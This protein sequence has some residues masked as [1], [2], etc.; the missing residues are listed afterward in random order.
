MKGRMSTT[1][2]TDALELPGKVGPAIL[3]RTYITGMANN[4]LACGFPTSFNWKQWQTAVV[5]VLLDPRFDPDKPVIKEMVDRNPREYAELL[6]EALA[7][8]FHE[9]GYGPLPL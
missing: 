8:S 5:P 2:L 6:G 1:L 7:V 3:S 9:A 4:S